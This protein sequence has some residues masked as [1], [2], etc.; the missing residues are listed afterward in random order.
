MASRQ[1]AV[2]TWRGEHTSAEVQEGTRRGQEGMATLARSLPGA[3]SSHTCTAREHE[4]VLVSVLTVDT[5][6]HADSGQARL[7]GWAQDT[8]GQVLAAAEVYTGE[9]LL[10]PAEQSRP[11]RRRESRV[12]RSRHT[13]RPLGWRPP[14][15]GS[16]TLG[17]APSPRPPQGAAVI[18]RETGPWRAR[19]CPCARPGHSPAER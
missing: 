16:S 2:V 10:S 1:G 8:A 6:H 15:S 5:E 3:R 14:R 7:Q 17:G 9:V 18:E 12:S 19:R 13:A 11:G 4:D